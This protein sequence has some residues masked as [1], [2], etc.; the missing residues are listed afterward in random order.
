[1]PFS[2]VA[3]EVAFGETAIQAREGPC[4][5]FDLS[6]NSQV[7]EGDPVVFEG[8]AGLSAESDP[9][10]LLS[11]LPKDRA[12]HPK[13]GRFSEAK[14]RKDHSPSFFKNLS[15]VCWVHSGIDVEN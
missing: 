7:V 8:G 11:G 2:N 12:C 13:R 4:I 9:R 10:L 5:S 1:C 6:L 15:G 3:F 14:R